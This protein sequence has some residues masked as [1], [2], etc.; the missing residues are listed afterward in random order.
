[1]SRKVVLVLGIIFSLAL[2]SL[3]LAEDMTAP[4]A[5]VAAQATV[6]PEMQWLWGEAVSVDIEK[7]EVVVRYQDYDTD[8]EKEMVVGIDDKSTL[9]NIKSLA[10]IRPKDTLSIDY[11][12]I[13]EGKNIAKNISVEKA[14]G[15]EAVSD[16]GATE[17][18]TAEVAAAPAAAPAAETPAQAATS[19][20]PETAATQQ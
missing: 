20:T 19:N 13:S 9:E 6:E 4:E 11:K 16:A 8:Q 10:E 3:V 12:T 5:P 7:N 18:G 2:V 17:A 15:P 1:M 14:E